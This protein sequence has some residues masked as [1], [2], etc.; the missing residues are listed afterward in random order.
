[1]VFQVPDQLEAQFWARHSN[2]K[3]GWSRVSTGPLLVY[4]VYHRKW[5]LLVAGLLWTAL[6]PV[7]FPPP[8]D[9]AAWMTRAV[10]AE[11]WWI[12]DEGNR[13][14]GLSYP[15]ICNGGSAAA[16]A[17]TLYAA[18]RQK[19]VGTTLGTVLVLGLKLWWVRVLVR[20]YDQRMD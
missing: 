14:V 8:E 6:N 7:L 11:R 16:T 1:M 15:N 10:L 13:T 18:W 19:P 17:Y 2:P 4:A 5:R 12:R 20:Q 9:D 3:S